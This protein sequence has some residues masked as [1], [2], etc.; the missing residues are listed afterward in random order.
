MTSDAVGDD[1]RAGQHGA[2]QGEVKR[3]GVGAEVM[4]PGLPD[5]LTPTHNLQV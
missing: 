4:G 5:D 2:R 3:G 1:A